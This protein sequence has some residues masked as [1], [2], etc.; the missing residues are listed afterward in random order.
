[1]EDSHQVLVA[2][3]GSL[4]GLLVLVLSAVFCSWCFKNRKTADDEEGV[5]G[6]KYA[7][8]GLDEDAGAG[9][10]MFKRSPDDK[11]SIGSASSLNQRAAQSPMLGRKTIK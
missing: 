11:S 7:V 4:C 8:N 5:I 9:N 2:V 10:Q 1:M 3:V 6:K